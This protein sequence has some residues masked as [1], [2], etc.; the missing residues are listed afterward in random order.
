MRPPHPRNIYPP[1]TLTRPTN[2]DTHHLPAN[3]SYSSQ[4]RLPSCL[5]PPTPRTPSS[6][7]S[8]QMLASSSASPTVLSTSSSSLSRAPSLPF[9]S[10]PPPPTP[11]TS[12]QP[13]TR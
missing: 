3:A 1:C 6:V 4:T 5:H 12:P 2:P 7:L 10:S 11:T 13:I 9:S 8:L